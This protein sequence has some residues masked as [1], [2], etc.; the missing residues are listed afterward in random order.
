MNQLG[1]CLG[2]NDSGYTIPNHVLR[3][4]R[5]GVLREFYKA[6]YRYSLSED[7]LSEREIYRLKMKVLRRIVKD[8]NVILRDRGHKK[9]S[10]NDWKKEVELITV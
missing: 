7:D 10:H 6:E 5:K 2:K 4:A 1:L 9:L 8:I 3:E